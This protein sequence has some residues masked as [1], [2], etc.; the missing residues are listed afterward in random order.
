MVGL[1]IGPLI[2]SLLYSFL[3]YSYTFMI[4][5]GFLILISFVIKM[6]FNGD[7][8]AGMLSDCNDSF[9]GDNQYR[10]ADE[11]SSFCNDVT[12]ERLNERD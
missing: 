5:G 9:R 2:G 4:Y 1:I 7:A 11:L 6:N 12:P 3:G 8:E 10:Y